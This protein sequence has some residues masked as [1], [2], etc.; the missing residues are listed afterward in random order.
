MIG[1]IITTFYFSSF[2]PRYFD[3]SLSYTARIFRCKIVNYVSPSILFHRY[4]LD[5]LINLERITYF[6]NSY[7]FKNIFRYNPILIMVLLLIIVFSINL[8]SFF[9]LRIRNDLEFD[10]RLYDYKTIKNFEYCDKEAFSKT[11]IGNIFLL[12][13]FLLRDLGTLIAEI[14]ASYKSFKL[15]Q[16]YLQKKSLLLHRNTVF[17]IKTSNISAQTVENKS[18]KRM[19][20]SLTKMTLLFSLASTICHVLSFICTLMLLFHRNEPYLLCAVVFIILFKNTSNIFFFYFFNKSFKKS[21]NGLI[22]S[23]LKILK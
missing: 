22:G 3:F 7:R 13:L 5:V 21:I 4:I 23:I 1:S 6:K 16:N 15:Y 18:S 17:N 12:I 10:Y 11:L 2:S 9:Q 20:C 14:L 19:N 8:P